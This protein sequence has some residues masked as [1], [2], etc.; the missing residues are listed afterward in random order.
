MED[1]NTIQE[2]STIFAVKVIEITDRIMH[3]IKDMGTL[4]KV[5]IIKD[6]MEVKVSVVITI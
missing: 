6:N 5:L 3:I 4:L 1:I 2:D